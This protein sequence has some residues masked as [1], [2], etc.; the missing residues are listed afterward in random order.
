M[1]SSIYNK[2][3]SIE[4]FEKKIRA[5]KKYS[6]KH[7]ILIIDEEAAIHKYLRKL[8]SLWG[9]EVISALNSIDGLEMAIERKPDLIILDFGM[10]TLKGDTMLKIFK[11]LTVTKNIPVI[12][13]SANLDKNILANAYKAGAIRFITKPFTQKILLKNLKESL[14]PD[15]VKE[16]K[17]S[18]L[19][20]E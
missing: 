12:I 1:S 5:E 3:D 17:L 2:F 4:E 8:F 20:P 6:K 18:V 13:I 16:M 10:P 9:F 7:S 15:I 19:T 14:N 11:R